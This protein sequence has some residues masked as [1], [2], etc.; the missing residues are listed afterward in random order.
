MSEFDP[1]A[2]EYESALDRGL[3]LS[4]ESRDFFAH[5]RVAWLRKCLVEQG[6]I[7]NDVLDFGC[8]VG[9]TM[10]ILREKLD[11]RRITGVDISARSIEIA[12]KATGSSIAQ[13]HVLAQFNAASEFDVAYCNGVFH[14]VPLAE[15]METAS[16][17]FRALKPNGLFALWDNNPL[18]PGARLVMNR[19]PF[20]RDAIM[21][22]A[23]EARR[24]LSAVGF[25]IVRTDFLF[26]FPHALR[27]LRILER[28]LLKVPLGAQFQV[29]ARHP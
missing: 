12:R 16:T 4:G 2:D 27:H 25:E 19:I 26:Y 23:R 11:P 22:S 15:R 10:P 7:A 5:A 21:L 1:Y 14:H 17:I 20:D 18:N 9:T 28:G 13:F 8:G 6:R 3:T 29:L 24:L